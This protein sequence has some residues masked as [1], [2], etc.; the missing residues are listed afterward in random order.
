MIARRTGPTLVD[1]V[2]GS[3]GG[4]CYQYGMLWRRIFALCLAL[5]AFAAP[6]VSYAQSAGD[7]Q[8]QDPLAGGNGSTGG[9]STGGGSTGGGSSSGS[10]GGSSGST[11]PSTTPAATTPGTTDPGTTGSSPTASDAQAP[12]QLPNTGFDVIVT[13][14]LGLAMLLLG[15]V[16]HRLLVLRDRR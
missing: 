9:G 8:Y 4:V 15:L 7:D 10:S 12:G 1:G 5:L 11:A 16:S 13:F 2:E 14:E 3:D 6:T